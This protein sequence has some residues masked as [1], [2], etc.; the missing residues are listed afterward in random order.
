MQT[1]HIARQPIRTFNDCAFLS[2]PTSKSIR[3]TSVRHSIQVRKQQLPA[4]TI[5]LQCTPLKTISRATSLDLGLPQQAA[6]TQEGPSSPQLPSNSANLDRISTLLAISSP[7]P[8]HKSTHPPS[9]TTAISLNRKGS[10]AL[11][12]AV[13]KSLSSIFRLSKQ[14]V[15]AQPNSPPSNSIP[16]RNTNSNANTVR[17]V[18]LSGALSSLPRMSKHRRTVSTPVLTPTPLKMDKLDRIPNSHL[19][20]ALRNRMITPISHTIHRQ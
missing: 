8:P 11:P 9:G 1:S 10:S 7:V 17:K 19:E 3:I 18:P 12:Q 14:T 5:D 2:R 20:Y 15:P 4:T 13:L 6:Q 16:R